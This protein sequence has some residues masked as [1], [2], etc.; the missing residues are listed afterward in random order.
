MKRRLILAAGAAAVG[1]DHVIRHGQIEHP[2]V[3]TGV[4]GIIA[5]PAF[6]AVDHS[7]APR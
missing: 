1:H 7:C 2:G 4:V 6:H 3:A 5:L